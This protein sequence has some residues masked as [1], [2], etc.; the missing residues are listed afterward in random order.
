[1][2]WID[3]PQLLC[4][5]ERPITDN[6]VPHWGCSRAARAARPNSFVRAVTRVCEV[7][8]ERALP[9]D[10]GIIR[11]ERPDGFNGRDRMASFAPV[12]SQVRRDSALT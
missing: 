1:M 9:P 10:T 2:L 6:A 12:D 4:R 5:H 7:V 3:L 11:R 8:H